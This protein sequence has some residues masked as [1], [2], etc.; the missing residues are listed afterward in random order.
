MRTARL[1]YSGLGLLLRGVATWIAW[2][3]LS[4]VFVAIAVGVIASRGRPGA[5]TT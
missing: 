3:R 1:R 2:L 5:K 4:H